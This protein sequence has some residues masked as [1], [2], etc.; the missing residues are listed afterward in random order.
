MSACRPKLA[1]DPAPI[2]PIPPDLETCCGSGCDPCVFDVYEVARDRY[3]TA[4]SAWQER[5]S[6]RRASD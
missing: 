4:L 6:V 1:D 2:P 5:Q 3:L